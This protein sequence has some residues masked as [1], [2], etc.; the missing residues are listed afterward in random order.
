MMKD[1]IS[2]QY[3]K[4]LIFK[5]LLCYLYLWFMRIFLN[6][7]HILIVKVQFSLMK[8]AETVQTD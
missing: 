7:F 1:Y 3:F 5:V 2:S 8:E 4:S 6:A